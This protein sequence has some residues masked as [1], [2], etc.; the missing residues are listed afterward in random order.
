VTALSLG[1]STHYFGFRPLAAHAEG[2]PHHGT[3]VW[4]V[5]VHRDTRFNGEVRETVIRLA[6]HDCGVVHMETVDGEPGTTET[7]SGAEIGYVAQP[8]RVAGLWLWTGPRMFYRDQA[9][10]MAFYVTETKKRP[11]RR[12]ETVGVVSWGLRRQRLGNGRV[13]G[14]R[15]C[16]RGQARRAGA[17]AVA[18]LVRVILI[19]AGVILAVGAAGLVGLLAFRMRH[20]LAGAARVMPPNPGAVSPLHGVARAAQPLPPLRPALERPQEVHLHL[21]GVSAEGI[22]AI[23]RS[24]DG[25]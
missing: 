9:G 21:H 17:G 5:T 7:T 3:D 18:E 12:A 24:Q 23:L 15:R 11:R 8:E 4:E 16:A 20:R 6:C 19:V 25:S 14:G 22:A 2:C 10:P 13:R 1:I